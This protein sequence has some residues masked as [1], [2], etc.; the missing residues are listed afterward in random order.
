[1][2][3]NEEVDK[4]IEERFGK[5]NFLLSFSLPGNPNLIYTPM[6]SRK[7][8]HRVDRRKDFRERAKEHG[9]W[10]VQ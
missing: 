1:M 5:P 6:G 2:V 4:Y 3:R 7:K 8:L 9:S 10:E